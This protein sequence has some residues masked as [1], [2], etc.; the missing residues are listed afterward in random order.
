MN[1]APLKTKKCSA[2][3]SD[4]MP[5]QKEAARSAARLAFRV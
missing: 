5:I 2:P 1:K 4:R 3:T